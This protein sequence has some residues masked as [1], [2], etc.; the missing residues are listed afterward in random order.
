VFS[1]LEKAPTLRS[2]RVFVICVVTLE[3]HGEHGE[4]AA[5]RLAQTFLFRSAPALF[6]QAGYF[7]VELESLY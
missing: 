4:Y 2:M 5:G 1:A 7:A 6:Q 3:R